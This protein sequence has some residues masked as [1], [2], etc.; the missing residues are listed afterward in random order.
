MYVFFYVFFLWI[1]IIS[2]KLRA[3]FE[4]FTKDILFLS[5]SKE[6]N[7]VFITIPDAPGYQMVYTKDTYKIPVSYNFPWLG[8][9]N[10]TYVCW[11]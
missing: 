11:H 9:E 10:K 6:K 5:S 8:I 2:K 4:S 3:I 1:F 7:I